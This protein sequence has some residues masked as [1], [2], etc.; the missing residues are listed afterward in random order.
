MRLRADGGRRRSAH[1]PLG[2]LGDDGVYARLD[3]V[4]EDLKGE[5]KGVKK[6]DVIV[7]RK[8]LQLNHVIYG[9]DRF[10]GLDQVNVKESQWVMR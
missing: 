4:A 8:T 10:P 2:A 7:L 3:A 1:D 9:D 5:L 6:E